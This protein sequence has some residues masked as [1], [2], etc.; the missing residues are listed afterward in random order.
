M[1][2]GERRRRRRWRR[3]GPEPEPASQGQ[4]ALTY[5]TDDAGRA[6]GAAP[7]LGVGVSATS[8]LHPGRLGRLGGQF[9]GP[10]GSSTSVGVFAA[11]ALVAGA[12]DVAPDVG[13]LVEEQQDLAQAL[14]LGGEGVLDAHGDV[15]DDAALDHALADELLEAIAE[16]GV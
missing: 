14:A 2:S 9:A 13:P 4:R 10:P 5:G 6:E 1:G 11:S 3:R 16:D 8:A 12:G 7:P 15:G